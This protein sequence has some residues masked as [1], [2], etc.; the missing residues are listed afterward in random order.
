MAQGNSYR[1]IEVYS[2]QLALVLPYVSVVKKLLYLKWYRR[3][4]MTIMNDVFCLL[5]A[6]YNHLIIITTHLEQYFYFIY[7]ICITYS[8]NSFMWTTDI[9]MLPRRWYL[10]SCTSSLSQTSQHSCGDIPHTKSIMSLSSIFVH[11][12]M[13]LGASAHAACAHRQPLDWA[14]KSARGIFLYSASCCCCVPTTA[15]TN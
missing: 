12:V 11:L 10:R 13:V 15:L 5:L 2:V 1:S 6:I 4:M 3:K 14:D 7:N 8:Y 9:H